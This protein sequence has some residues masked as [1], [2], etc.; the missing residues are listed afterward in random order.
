MSADQP[1]QYVFNVRAMFN[2]VRE[3]RDRAVRSWCMKCH[4]QLVLETYG[5]GNQWPETEYIA[6]GRLRMGW[7][8]GLEAPPTVPLNKKRPIT[9]WTQNGDAAVAKLD[10]EFEAIGIQ[11]HL[12]LYN[13]VGYG[14]YV[15]EGM[16]SHK[17]IGPRP[18]VQMFAE[19]G[20]PQALL[21]QS[22]AEAAV[23]HPA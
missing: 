8:W 22:L 5:P 7:T 21:E 14:W 20:H 12:V 4:R 2:R 16:G 1:S 11:A 15:H 19:S 23:A 18:W 3:Q 9:D 10:A 13:V 17:M 6:V